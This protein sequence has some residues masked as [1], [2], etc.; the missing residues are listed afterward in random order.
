M[1]L[2]G[3]TAGAARSGAGT[4]LFHQFR[5]LLFEGCNGGGRPFHLG[6]RLGGEALRGTAGFLGANCSQLGLTHWQIT[7]TAH[8]F[9]PNR[10]GRA[11]EVA[12]AHPRSGPPHGERRLEVPEDERQNHGK[13]R[14]DTEREGGG[15]SSLAAGQPE[16]AGIYLEG[17]KG[18]RHIA[19]FDA[20]AGCSTVGLPWPG[21][22]PGR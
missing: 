3:R 6:H 1:R 21:L 13:T 19:G 16:F 2:R 9:G 15:P 5:P 10:I 7:L 22:C 12:A 17:E 20:R 14:K 8:G 11:T 18:S 4:P